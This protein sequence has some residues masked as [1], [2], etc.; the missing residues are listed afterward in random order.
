MPKYDLTQIGSMPIFGGEI[1]LL[2]R[3]LLDACNA[4]TYSLEDRIQLILLRNRLTG[5][6]VDAR[7][8]GLEE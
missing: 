1:E 6:A 2:R 3:V 4:S 8:Q 7:I 5:I